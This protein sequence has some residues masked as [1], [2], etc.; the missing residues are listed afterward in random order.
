VKSANVSEALDRAQRSAD[1]LD[2]ELQ[3]VAR[4]LRDLVR[5]HDRRDAPRPRDSLSAVTISASG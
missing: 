1:L 2:R 5:D 4:D 3:D